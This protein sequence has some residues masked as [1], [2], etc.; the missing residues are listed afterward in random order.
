MGFFLPFMFFL[1]FLLYLSAMM[2]DYDVLL[3]FIYLL[4]IKRR[5]LS[6]IIKRRMKGWYMNNELGRI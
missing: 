1:L 2:W 3:V 4:F 6:K 5:F